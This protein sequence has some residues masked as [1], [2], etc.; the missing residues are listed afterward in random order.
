MIKSKFKYNTK[1]IW[2]IV[3]VSIIAI[4]NILY[5]TKTDH[6]YLSKET[7]QCIDCHKKENIHTSQ[8][9]EWSKSE[10][11]LKGVGCFECHTAMKEDSDAWNHE[12]IVISK[13]VSPK[14]CSKC[15]IKEFKEFDSSHHAKGGEIL[16]SIDNYIGEVVEGPGASIQGCQSCHG[17]IIKINKD[18]S[19]DPKTWPNIG[20]GRLNPDGSK[21]SCSACHSKHNFSMAVARNP[22]SCAKCHIGPDHPQIEI[23]EESIHGR[24][25]MSKEK[26]M[27]L[28]NPEWILGKDY[29]AAP[30]C[31]TCHMG[32]SKNLLKT[33]DIGNR[34]SL[35]L[36][37]VLSKPTDNSD[38]KR[39]NMKMICRNCHGTEWFNN[40][41]KQLDSTVDLYNNQYAGPATEIM[42]RLRAKGVLTPQPLDEEIEWIYFE[43]WHHEG[44]RVRHGAAMMGPDYVQWHGFYELAHNF[45]FKFLPLAKEL[46]ETE[47]VEN[48]LN[49]PEHAWIKGY[50]PENLKLQEAAFEKWQKLKQQQVNRK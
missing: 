8:I 7:K 24:I 33:H 41:Y 31:V 16:G 18:G 49:E 36:R 37:S 34:L 14:D 5:F 1:T 42:N 4:F 40:F 35:D 43:L 15:H 10:H 48:L 27:N 19:I 47:Y 45:Y 32:G 28:D 39:E 21:G 29:T 50:K 17:S 13:I 38:A 6:I 20:I 3:G 9:V 2:L 23:Y 25:F 22:R 12:G 11:A 44:R 30:N 26:D 46:G